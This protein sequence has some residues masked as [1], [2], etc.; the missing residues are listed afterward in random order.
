MTGPGTPRAAFSAAAFADLRAAAGE[1]QGEAL[2]LLLADID[3]D[4]DQPRTVFDT[5]D[6]AQLAESIR[7][8]GVLQPIVVRPPVEG[9]YRLAFGA[10]RLRAAR[11]AGLADIPAVIRRAEP[12]DFAAQV[13]E[14]RQRADLSNRDLAAAVARLAADGHTNRQIG[15]I[16]A[17]KGYQVAAFRQAGS[18][19]PALLERMDDSDMRAL[20]D[21][22]RQWCRTPDAVIAALP[23]AG[24]PITVTEA[25]RIVGAITGRPT[26]SLVLDRPAAI[27]PHDP[28]PDAAKSRG[29][30][31]AS[32]EGADAGP[33]RAAN[34]PVP[35]VSGPAGWP[36]FHVALD[37]GRTGRL[38]VDRRAARPGAALVALASGTE[39]VDAAGLRIIRV[40]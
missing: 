10:R 21:L 35:A 15:T 17:L 20:Y 34:R 30:H 29:L 33:L 38:V 23:A 39:E 3:E 22:Y 2:R 1:G 40:D 11:L 26:G 18:F 9:R 25:R 7:A 37:D 19:P 13:I 4:P 36:A 14:N 12:G 5:E 32:P 28:A 16:C 24:S 27:R 6:L 8:H 31:G